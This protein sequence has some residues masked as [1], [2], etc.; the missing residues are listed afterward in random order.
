MAPA[1]RREHGQFRRDRRG[2]SRPARAVIGR[3]RRRRDR[4]ISDE[5]RAR[6]AAEMR[7]PRDAIEV[8]GPHAARGCDPDPNAATITA[9]H[10]SRGAR[11]RGA[12]PSTAGRRLR[13]ASRNRRTATRN[14]ARLPGAGG[15]ALAQASTPAASIARASS[16]IP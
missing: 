1:A 10:A 5:D 11:A 8:R 12:R 7:G 6:D 13:R 16:C 2:H 3:R 4:R 15:P 9:I 14:G